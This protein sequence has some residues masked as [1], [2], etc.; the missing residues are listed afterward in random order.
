M[1]RGMS[2]EMVLLVLPMEDENDGSSSSNAAS[3]AP[4][5]SPSLLLKSIDACVQGFRNGAVISCAVTNTH[6]LGEQGG[7]GL[8]RRRPP[9]E[10][11]AGQEIRLTNRAIRRQ[12]FRHRSRASSLPAHMVT[13]YIS[14]PNLF[15]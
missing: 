12:I 6:T 5:H 4:L 3:A 10:R 2:S 9:R 7:D 1:V 8:L 15:S 11:R 13:G 14:L